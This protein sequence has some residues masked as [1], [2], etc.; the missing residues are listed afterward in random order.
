MGE[1][2]PQTLSDEKDLSVLRPAFAQNDGQAEE[3]RAPRLSSGGCPTKQ[4]KP[5]FKAGGAG[6]QW[7]SQVRAAAGR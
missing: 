2:G 6:L 5:S 3:H 7:G 1:E 4:K